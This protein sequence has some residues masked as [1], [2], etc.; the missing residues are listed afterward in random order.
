VAVGL[1]ASGK[2]RYLA[3][4]G[5]NPITS[6]A[7]RLQLVDDET[8]QT[9][10]ARVFAAVRYL[11]RERIALRRPLTYIDA[12]NLTRR[13]RRPYIAM[14]REHDCRVEALWFDTPLV[15]CKARNAARPR[16][17]PE[18]V[19]DLMAARFVPPSREEGFDEVMVVR[20]ATCFTA[21]D[22]PRCKPPQSLANS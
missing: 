19:L 16:V 4:L 6:D 20:C 8:D 22:S 1:P 21:P 15:L 7:I 9:I 12:T 10:N 17:V 2:S 5:V 13:D 14:A 18:R 3:D 11:L